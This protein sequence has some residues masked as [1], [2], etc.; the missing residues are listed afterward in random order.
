M[1]PVAWIGSSKVWMTVPS[2]GSGS[3]SARFSARVF[4]VT[5]R[6]SPCSSPSSSM[7]FMITGM[8]P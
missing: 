5:V 2:I 1:P 8:P 6:A 3:S 4:P 7:A